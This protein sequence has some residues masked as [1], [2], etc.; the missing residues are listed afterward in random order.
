[1]TWAKFIGAAV[2]EFQREWLTIEGGVE[3]FGK[4]VGTADKAI[5]LMAA[6]AWALRITNQSR[7]KAETAARQAARDDGGP[8]RGIGKGESRQPGSTAARR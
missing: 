7:L 5:R 3:R 8:R 6:L 1:M 4:R 2:D